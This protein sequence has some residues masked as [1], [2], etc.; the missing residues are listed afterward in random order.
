MK[1]NPRAPLQAK[2]DEPSV[3]A[4]RI[5]LR[6]LSA[7]ACSLQR[8]VHEKVIGWI[9]KPVTNKKTI[10]GRLLM[11]DFKEDHLR[12]RIHPPMGQP[13]TCRFESSLKDLVRNA[14]TN[15]VRVTGESTEERDGRVISFFVHDLDNIGDQENRTETSHAEESFFGEAPTLEE[16]AIQQDVE[17]I[18]SLAALKGSFWPADETADEFVSSI[19]RWRQEGADS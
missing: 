14:L 5:S 3:K 7:L 8:V 18:T 2:L 17:P 16:L 11:G 1:K 15:Y 13:V 10:E 4:G 12:C 9:V 6:E 19:R